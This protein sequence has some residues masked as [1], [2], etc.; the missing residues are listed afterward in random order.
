MMRMTSIMRMTLPSALPLRW[1]FALATLCIGASGNAS[2]GGYVD[3]S[4]SMPIG[5][6]G[7]DLRGLSGQVLN[8]DPGL[9]LGNAMSALAVAERGGD[10]RAIHL[11]LVQKANAEQHLGLFTEFLQ[12]TLRAL[13]VAQTISDPRLMA[14]DLQNLSTAYGANMRPDNAIAEAKNALAMVLPT[15]DERAIAEAQ[16]FLIH[17]L[18]KGGD[19][20]EALKV[21]EVA[22]ERA[23]RNND[24][25][26]QARI[27]LLMAEAFM[28]QERHV[29]ALPFL[30]KA[31]RTLDVSGTF[32]E[33]FMLRVDRSRAFAA[34]G[35][36]DEADKA[37][38]GAIGM[39]EGSDS[40]SHQAAIT[41]ARYELELS[42]GDW[43]A[44]LSHLQRIK[45]QDDSLARAHVDLKMAGLQM[46][47]QMDRKDRDNAALRELNAQNE[48]IIAD[49]RVNNRYLWVLVCGVLVFGCACFFISRHSLRV[50]KRLKRKNLVVRRQHEEIEAKN[51]E[52]QRQNLRL[53]ETLISEEEKEIMIKEIHHR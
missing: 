23:A 34:I 48:S 1:A 50:M 3:G 13:E 44:A 18:N 32:N 41:K 31:E 27:W 9:A 25:L 47:Y 2:D 19:H 4:W 15:Q 33:R 51:L 30:A 14:R 16:L 36:A 28:E 7:A 29:D 39:M 10:G 42:R 26:V 11:A 38:T 45:D 43:R 21:G 20:L 8:K 22:L 6:G 49:Q 24:E 46:A 52:L 37:L 35:R 40:W 5:P 53:A 17:T 12:T